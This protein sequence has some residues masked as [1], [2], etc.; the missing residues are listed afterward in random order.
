MK[1][2][3]S[4]FLW[5]IVFTPFISAQTILE[6]QSYQTGFSSPVDI[7]NAGDGSNRLFIVEKGGIIKIIKN[8]S[9]LPTPFL[10]ISSFVS[11]NGERGLLGLAFHPNYSSN[12][13]FYVNYT[14]NSGDTQIVR[15]GTNTSNP[16]LADPANRLFILTIAQP[17][18]NHNAG[19][20]EFG[21]DA[22]LYIPMG[23]GGSGNDPGDRSQDPQEMLGKMLR[24]DVDLSLIHI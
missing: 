17:F 3:F 8:G 11:S 24:I 21:P 13:Y 18:S 9:V 14:D 6:F 15:F 20:L 23:D 5:T 4:L 22:Y 1:N 16:D 12:G 2:L 10:N 19:D 7:A